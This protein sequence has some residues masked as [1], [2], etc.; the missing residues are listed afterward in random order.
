MAWIRPRAQETRSSLLIVSWLTQELVQ[1]RLQRWRLDLRKIGPAL[2][3]CTRESWAPSW[4]EEPGLAHC[5]AEGQR[6]NPWGDPVVLG[7]SVLRPV[8]P[9]QYPSRPQK[10]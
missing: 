6:R 10:R 8:A 2:M 4:E 7:R 3:Q 1:I 9:G 5:L